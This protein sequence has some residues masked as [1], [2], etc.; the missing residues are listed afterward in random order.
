[1][2]SLF[3]SKNLRLVFFFYRP[4]IWIS[5]AITF[6]QFAILKSSGIGDI[7]LKILLAKLVLFG[8]LFLYYSNVRSR[9]QLIFYKNFGISKL[10]LFFI[11]YSM[12]VLLT[13]L[14]ILILN[15]F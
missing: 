5:T 4:F 15:L 2:R 1:M 9:Q 11:S 8:L 12:D 10:G 14:T 7:V 13:I 6:I 3:R